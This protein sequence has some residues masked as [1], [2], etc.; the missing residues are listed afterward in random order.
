MIKVLQQ[1]SC[2]IDTIV[3]S[4]FIFLFVFHQQPDVQT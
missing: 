3:D 4:N 1:D 2:L